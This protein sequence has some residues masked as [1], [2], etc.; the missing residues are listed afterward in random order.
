MLDNLQFPFVACNGQLAYKHSGPCALPFCGLV[1]EEH[2]FRNTAAK[3]R[4]SLSQT[5]KKVLHCLYFEAYEHSVAD[6]NEY[7]HESTHCMSVNI[8]C[9]TTNV[10]L[11]STSAFCLPHA[12]ICIHIK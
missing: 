5:L 12:Y 9:L 3:S 11:Q 8:A 7:D 1:V 6:V 2:Y 4:I 10:E